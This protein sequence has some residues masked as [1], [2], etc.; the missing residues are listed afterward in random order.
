[1][2]LGDWLAQDKTRTQEWL[3]RRI[4]RTQGRIS[5]LVRGSW[6]SFKEASRIAEVT[7]GEVTANDW[8]PEMEGVA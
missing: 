7:G 5:Q 2:K 4:G 6:P 1:M 8:L 3:G